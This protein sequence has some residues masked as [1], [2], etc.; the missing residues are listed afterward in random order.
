[1]FQQAFDLEV[2]EKESFQ[3]TPS[4][5]VKII[6]KTHK[7]IDKTQ[8]QDRIVICNDHEISFPHDTIIYRQ[9][10][11]SESKSDCDIDVP[12]YNHNIRVEGLEARSF[13]RVL[14]QILTK[15]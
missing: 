5:L 13:L 7:N 3:D 6:W 8:I 15:E 10:P 4:D 9:L 12:R 11:L 2:A 1:M 14:L